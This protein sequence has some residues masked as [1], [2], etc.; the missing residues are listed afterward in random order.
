MSV[1]NK[2]LLSS[3]FDLALFT[4]GGYRIFTNNLEAMSILVAY[5]FFICGLIGFVFNVVKLS[6]IPRT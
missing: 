5:I 2:T 1:K 6:R 3:V 4:L